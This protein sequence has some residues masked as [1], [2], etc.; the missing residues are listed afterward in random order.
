[1]RN[2]VVVFTIL[3]GAL[4]G[5]GGAGANA[6]APGAVAPAP[7]RFRFGPSLTSYEGVSHRVVEQRRVDGRMQESGSVLL[8]HLTAE[9]SDADS[10]LMASFVIDTVLD[11]TAQNILPKEIGSATGARFHAPLSRTGALGSLAGGDATSILSGQLER[12]IEDFFP[13]VPADGLRASANWVDTTETT[14]DQSGA[15]IAV[16]AVTQYRSADWQPDAE[17]RQV[18]TVLWDRTYE[19]HGAG[20]QFGQA[21]TIEGTGT[22]RG[23][24]LLSGGGIFLGSSRE[25]ELRGQILLVSIG[26]TTQI[27]Q[28]QADTIRVRQ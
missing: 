14:R 21:F 19:L 1:M 18:L 26:D 7:N 5:C 9:I 10:T 23:T 6:S 17:G 22:A 2:R 28:T 4:A 16:R 24:A 3:V 11:A 20:D 25:D 13:R 27:R 15:E 8:Y 12:Q